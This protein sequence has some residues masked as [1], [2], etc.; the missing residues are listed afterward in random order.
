ML[1]LNLGRVV[2]EDEAKAIGARIASTFLNQAKMAVVR[3]TD[4]NLKKYIGREEVDEIILKENATSKPIKDEA[5]KL[6]KEARQEFSETG[7]YTN[8]EAKLKEYLKVIEE[9]GATNQDARRFVNLVK[10]KMRQV[11]SGDWPLYYDSIYWASSNR[12]KLEVIKRAFGEKMTKEDFVE[13]AKKYSVL[14]GEKIDREVYDDYFKT[15]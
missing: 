4:K 2:K 11:D 5:N 12:A 9:K 6:V 8:V 3:T 10:N 7:R 14:T 15:R 1:A 13:F